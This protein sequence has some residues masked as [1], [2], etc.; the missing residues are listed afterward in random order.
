MEYVMLFVFVFV[1]WALHKVSLFALAMAGQAYLAEESWLRFSNF[2]KS[3]ATSFML[4][5]HLK[6]E[7]IRFQ[8]RPM[9]KE[10]RQ[11]FKKRMVMIGCFIDWALPIYVD[12]YSADIAARIEA[13]LRG[14]EEETYR[15]PVVSPDILDEL[16]F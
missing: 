8:N 1:A 6:Y 7:A 3:H 10:R 9:N 13:D 15:P 16:E 14:D 11:V 4:E 2:C 5:V 12:D